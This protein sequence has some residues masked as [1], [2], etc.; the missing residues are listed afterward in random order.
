MAR[1]FGVQGDG[2]LGRHDPRQRLLDDPAFGIRPR[3]QPQGHHLIDERLV[4]GDA[5]CLI[6]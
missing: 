1:I 5:V 6:P 3:R 4:N 2:I